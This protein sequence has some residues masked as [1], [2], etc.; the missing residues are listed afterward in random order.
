MFKV[1]EGA[2][3]MH[4]V[5]LRAI[6]ARIAWTSSHWMVILAHHVV[7]GALPDLIHHGTT[8]HILFCG[9]LHPNAARRGYLVA[10]YA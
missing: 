10:A 4:L 9:P 1:R 3:S 6:G 2:S 8:T 5:A 7:Q